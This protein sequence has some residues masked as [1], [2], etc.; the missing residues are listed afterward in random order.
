M[1]LVL[2]TRICLSGLNEQVFPYF[3]T[4]VGLEMWASQK[5]NAG[6]VKAKAGGGF[7]MWLEYAPR[8]KI[9]A[10]G[11]V[12]LVYSLVWEERGL[13]LQA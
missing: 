4:G 9:Q 8:L 2:D 6:D 7:N 11:E 3:N 13:R 10:A 5:K 12:V 1:K